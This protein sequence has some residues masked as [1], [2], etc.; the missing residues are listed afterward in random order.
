MILHTCGNVVSVQL[1]EDGGWYGWRLR[2]VLEVGCVAHMTVKRWSG[3]G[4]MG[5]NVVKPQHFYYLAACK[6]ISLRW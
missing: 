1:S 3:I 2:V 4:Y 5:G 6:L